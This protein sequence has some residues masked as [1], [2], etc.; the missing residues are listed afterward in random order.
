MVGSNRNV[1]SATSRGGNAAWPWLGL[2]AAAVIFVV[3]AACYFGYTVDDAYISLRYARNVAAGEGFAFDGRVPPV[4]GY[5]NFLWVLCEVPWYALQPAGDG[6]LYAKLLGLGWGLAALAAAFFAARRLWGAGAGAVAA[7]SIA[8]LGNVAFWAVGGLEAA[9]YLCLVLLALFFTWDAGRRRVAAVLAGALWCMA[10]L[11]R[12]EG[13]VLACVVISAAL[14]V[15][16]E[17]ARGRRGLALAGIVLLATYG[18][19]FVWRWHYFGMFLP[20]TFYARAGVTPWSLLARVRQVLPFI[21][22]AVPPLAAAWALGCGG[23]DRRVLLLWVATFACLALAF[24]ARR[25]WMPGFRYEL[26]FAVL[27]W[28]LFAGAWVRVIKN[29]GKIVAGVL[30]AAV[31]VYAFIPGIFLFRETSYTDGLDGAH[32]ALGKWLAEAGPPGSSLATWDMG[33]LPYYSAFPTIYDLNPEGLLSRETT[34]RGYR[35]DY[36]LSQKPT[37]VVLYSSEADRVAA[38]PGHWTYGYYD[39]PAFAAGYEY[40][41]T[42][43]MR[44]GYHLRVYVD[45]DTA[46]APEDLAAGAE[47]ARRS[48]APAG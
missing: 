13:F 37:Y 8:A 16:G 47:L 11:A 35:P 1:G 3:L 29:R 39:A 5:T 6:V 22:Y 38:P 18:A 42:F 21:M 7:L 34:S 41:F 33:A 9:Q 2:A 48:R 36:F 4:E 31:L 32:A 23:K 44:P 12:P 30:T 45:K 15:G 20:N 17:G 27:A 40:L 24:V 25:E 14:L 26:P 46:L 28:V 19:Y 43:T 10:A